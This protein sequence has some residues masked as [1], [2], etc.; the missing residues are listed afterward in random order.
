MSWDSVP[1]FVGGGAEH[2]P[3][4]ARLLAY[5]AVGGA[6]GLVNPEDLKVSPLAVPGGGVRVAP[7]AAL[8][9]NRAAGGDD[10]TYVARL[11]DTDTVTIAATGSGAGRT[12]LIVAQIEDPYM[13]GEPWQEPTDPKIGPYVYTRVIPNVPAGTKRL[14]DVAGYSGRSAITL[15]RVTLPAST[16]TVTAAMITDLRD[17]ARPRTER[18]MTTVYPSGART[19]GN[20]LPTTSYAPW[21]LTSAQRPLVEVPSWAT[22]IDIVV[23]IS[24]T[25]FMKSGSTSD[26]VAGVR[27]VFGS[28]T[29]AENGILIQDVEDADG[30]YH[31]TVIGSH[32][33]PASMRGTSQYIEAQAVRTYG[34]GNWYADYQTSVVVDWQFSEGAA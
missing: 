21:P 3:E 14:Q 19:A 13:A 31:Y 34:T 18:R 10:Q 17:L 4:V 8:I 9:R 24:G 7:G 1:W 25:L 6:E 2:S 20:K 16:G 30:R 15:A 23:H 29:P 33:I 5:A 28:T 26:S 32:A 12:D 27:T 11:P 22:K